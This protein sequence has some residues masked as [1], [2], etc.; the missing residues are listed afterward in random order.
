MGI[1]IE[2]LDNNIL[3]LAIMC[4][5]EYSYS[6]KVDSSYKWLKF[7]HNFLS[8]FEKHIYLSFD[9]STRW[10][11]NNTIESTFN[12][13]IIVVSTWNGLFHF[14]F[15]ILHISS[16]FYIITVIEFNYE[17]WVVILDFTAME[18]FILVATKKFLKDFISFIQDWILTLIYITDNNLRSF[19]LVVWML[20]H[21]VLI[22]ETV[23]NF[24]WSNSCLLCFRSHF[25]LYF[26][27]I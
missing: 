15:N 14:I 18:N 3:L 2:I 23:F 7:L 22:L 21:I 13:F 6:Y 4:K 8:V 17:L 12:V 1:K 5:L 10:F 11:D 9:F 27:L 24:V 20:N 26:E 25:Y 16:L 19:L